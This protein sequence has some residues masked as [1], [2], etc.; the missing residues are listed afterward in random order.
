MI[1]KLKLQVARL[2]A[3]TQPQPVFNC[4]YPAQMMALAVFIV[5]H[6]GSL[7][8]AAA[9]VGFYSQELMGWKYGTPTWKTISNWVERC[10]LH[11]LN[12]TRE[13]SGE[14]I[15]IID[16][17][18]QI[19]K[20]QLMLLLGVKSEDVAALNRPLTMADVVVLGME[21]QSSW[22]GEAVADFIR[23]NLQ[24]RPA[25]ELTYVVC[26]QGTNLLAALRQLN[27]A[28]VSDCSHVMMNLVKKLFTDDVALS[29]LCAEVGQLRQRLSLT[30]QAFL[31]PP[32]LR[33]KDRFLRVFTLVEWMDR[34]N[35]YWPNLSLEIRHR[36]GFI[37]CHWLN[38][39]LRQ[40]YQLLILTSK[41]LKYK[42]LNY[43]THQ[44]WVSEITAWQLTQS[45]LTKQAREFIK[46]MEAYFVCYCDLYATTTKLLCCSDIIECVF[47][48]YKNKGGMKAISAD[49]LAIALYNQSLTTRFIQ[50]AMKSVNGPTVDQWRCANVCHNRYGVRRRMEKEL[51]NAGG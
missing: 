4:T 43:S 49:V 51:K 25:I 47:G 21:V 23:R 27:I 33:D 48:R 14:Y 28:V 13:L 38:L 5:L 45:R 12:L 31:L 24:E 10:G 18:I 8:C 17:S 36:L 2:E 22:D 26:D 19:G 7:R 15:A 9:T 3:V 32:S 44:Q 11:A 35:G 1:V 50:T 40:V 39:R 16:A 37:H 42:G 30:D 29:K 20:E 6:G 34:I 46:G 41:L